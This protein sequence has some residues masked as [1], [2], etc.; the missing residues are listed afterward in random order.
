MFRQWI[1]YFGKVFKVETIAVALHFTS[2]DCYQCGAR[3][4]KS[5]YTHTH[6]CSCGLILD[7]NTLAGRN[8]LNR[9]LNFLRPGN[10]K[11]METK[12]LFCRG[13]ARVGKL[14]L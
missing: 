5:L 6:A 14:Y 1:E 4:K 2:Q 7:K 9:G 11:P 12:P 10:S 13:Q 3:I 8:I